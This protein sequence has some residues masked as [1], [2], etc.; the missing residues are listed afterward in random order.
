MRSRNSASD[1]AVAQHPAELRRAR[2]FLASGR[3][4]D[5]PPGFHDVGGGRH[6]LDR[7][8]IREVQRVSGGRGDRGVD[9]LV[10]GL[11]HHLRDELDAGPVRLLRVSGEDAGDRAVPRQ[12]HVEQEIVPRHARDLEQFAVQRVVFDGAFDGARVAHELRAVQDLDGLLRGEP[13]RDQLPPARVAE[14]EVRLDK[15]ESDVEIR[16]R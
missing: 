4:Q 7:L 13:R 6:S 1:N 5:R 16:A 10:E 11:Q 9:G 14:H 12:R 8:V 3:Q 15:P 2:A